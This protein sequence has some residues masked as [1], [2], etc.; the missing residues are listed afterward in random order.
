MTRFTVDYFGNWR[1]LDFE[2]RECRWNGPGARLTPR[3]GAAL[4]TLE[5]PRCRETV[6]GGSHPTLEEAEEA[7]ERGN[8]EAR[9]WLVRHRRA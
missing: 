9:G 5:C 6:A 1:E 2:C 3:V 8:A 4:F 7:A